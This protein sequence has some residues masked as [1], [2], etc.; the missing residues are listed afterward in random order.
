MLFCF[1]AVVSS[2][3][4][5]CLTWRQHNNY[6]QFVCHVDDLHLSVT[7]T[8]PANDELAWCLIPLPHGKCLSLV[9]WVNV[10]QNL[11][12]NE[13][14]FSVQNKNSS[15]INGNWTCQHGFHGDEALIEVN[16]LGNY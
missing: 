3:I 9:P 11:A 10:T 16:I 15:Y 2:N 6:L 5:I 13:T 12:T 7:L 1:A 8:D 14:V 4:P